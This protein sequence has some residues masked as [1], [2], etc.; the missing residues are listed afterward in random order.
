MA[1]DLNLS[2]T[3]GQ[4]S[5]SGGPGLVTPAAD[6]GGAGGD[7]GGGSGGA[8]G[9]GLGRGSGGGGG[10]FQNPAIRQLSWALMFVALAALLVIGANWRVLWCFLL[11]LAGFAAFFTLLFW[12]RRVDA[13]TWF[14]GTSVA[15]LTAI[16]SA[17]GGAGGLAYHLVS[18]QGNLYLVNIREVQVLERQGMVPSSDAPPRPVSPTPTATPTPA[19][20]PAPGD[21]PPA[22]NPPIGRPALSGPDLTGAGTNPQPTASPTPTA[23]PPQT[24]LV[25]VTKTV[26]D[27]GFLADVLVGIIAANALHLAISGILKYNEPATNNV[28]FTLIALGVLVGFSGARVLPVWANTLLSPEQKNQVAQQVIEDPGAAAR[29]VKSA[30]NQPGVT[31]ALIDAVATP[32]PTPTATPTPPSA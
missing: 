9:G 23:T 14:R 8:N 31:Q 4:S 3:T 5:S 19:A 7:I 10:G 27:F 2:S 21:A 12:P 16:L 1:E 13:W 18:N 17:A 20:R 25:W 24:N 11:G 28:Y 29:I 30:I 32:T 6:A 22:A 15:L 26:F